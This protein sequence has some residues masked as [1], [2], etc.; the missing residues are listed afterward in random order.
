MPSSF[1]DL[2]G[3]TNNF[4]TSKIINP[5]AVAGGGS[6]PGQQRGT[7]RIPVV[8]GLHLGPISTYLG[9]TQFVL[10]FNEPPPS[11]NISHY[12]VFVTGALGNNQSPLGPFAS[13]A[14]PC[15][16]RITASSASLLTFT[17]QTVLGNGAVSALS[18]S[19]TC[20]G[21][22]INPTI[23]GTTQSISVPV[24]ATVSATMLPT[25]T[26]IFVVFAPVG[27][28]VGTVVITSCASPIDGQQLTISNVGANLGIIQFLPAP[29]QSGGHFASHAAGGYVTLQYSLAVTTWYVITSV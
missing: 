15:Y 4:V 6:V 17:I 19:P 16:L 12:N 11:A 2:S 10:L 7:T 22:S 23:A 25:D 1:F 9:G 20:T 29:G 8:T 24:A 26:I 27:G 14:S 5:N 18:D 3:Q 28:G 13:Q 21:Q